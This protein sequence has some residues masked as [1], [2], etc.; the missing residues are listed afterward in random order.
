MSLSLIPWKR[1]LSVDCEQTVEVIPVGSHRAP[2]L[3]ADLLLLSHTDRCERSKVRV[4]VRE[5]ELDIVCAK[6]KEKEAMS[7]V[8]TNKMWVESM[9]RGKANDT[10]F[11]VIIS[12]TDSSKSSIDK[13]LKKKQRDQSTHTHTQRDRQTKHTPHQLDIS[14]LLFLPM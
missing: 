7:G 2:S 3:P 14:A 4:C 11:A 9:S 13:H 1:R 12:N 8:R 10:N 6:R 5:G